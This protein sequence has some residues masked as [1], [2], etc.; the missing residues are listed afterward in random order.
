MGSTAAMWNM[1]SGDQ[2]RSFAVRRY[3]TEPRFMLLRT[4]ASCVIRQPF[5][6]AVVPEV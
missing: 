1:G 4:C 2:K 3:R 5:G 6:F